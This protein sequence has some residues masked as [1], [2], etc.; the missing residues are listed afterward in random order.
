V[1]VIITGGGSGARIESAYR[2]LRSLEKSWF[3]NNRS[4]PLVH[5]T[6]SMPATA[7]LNIDDH[8][9]SVRVSGLRGD[10]NIDTHNGPVDVDNH[11]GALTVD[12][13][14]SRVRAQFVTLAK[15]V[16]I[17]THNG[18]VEI[19]LPD[20]ARFHVNA[21]GHNMAVDSDFPTVTKKMSRGT[22]VGDVNGGG[23]EI[24]FS[25]HNGS[26]RLRRS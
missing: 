13:H 4:L 3:T 25:T 15:S 23:A 9:A 1:E 8:N 26:L 2:A 16:S 20:N 11:S 24:R 12:G 22:Y 17:E 10:L 19:R 6:I 14:N 21:S 18:P 7:S 5:Y